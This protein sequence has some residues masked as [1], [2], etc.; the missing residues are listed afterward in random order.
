[1]GIDWDDL[2]LAF[3]HDPPDKALRIKG[4][5][6][7]GARYASAALGEEITKTKLHDYSRT[8]DQLASMIERLPTPAPGL[9]PSLMVS[10]EDGGKLFIRHPISGDEI[11][12]TGCEINEQTVL[13]VISELVSGHEEPENRFLAVWRMLP[14]KLTLENDWY[15][16]LP[17]DTRV[18]DHTIWNH[19]DIT[20]ALHAA[21]SEKHGPAFLSFFLGPVQSFIASARSV[22]DLW[23][24]SAI[25]SWLTFQ[26][27]LPIIKTFGP[28]AVVFPSLRGLPWLDLWLRVERNLVDQ[29]PKPSAQDLKSPC[30]PNRFLAVVPWGDNGS[31]AKVLAG[32]CEKAV[33]ENWRK[34]SS[35]VRNELDHI[36]SKN[37]SDWSKRWEDQVESLFEIRS[38]VL[39]WRSS[40]NKTMSSL[41]SQNRE[42]DY[43]WIEAGKIQRLAKAIPDKDQPGYDQDHVGQWQARFELS[44]RLMDARRSIRHIP[45][46]KATRPTPPK[47]TLMGTYEQM[48]PDDLKES[49]KFWENVS[50]FVSI[51]GVRLQ[52]SE[53]FCAISLVKR[54]AFPAFLADKIGLDWAEVGFPDTAT[55]A[56][57]SWLPKAHLDPDNLRMICRRENTHWN[58][59]WLH[60]PK[61][62][63]DPDEKVPLVVWNLIRNAKAYMESS[64]VKAGPPPTYYA[65]LMMDGDEMGKWLRGDKGSLVGQVYQQKIVKYYE[66]LTQ[67][68]PEVKEALQARRPL[69]P[70]LH[71]AISQALANFAIHIAPHIVARH[72][73]TL[74]YAGGDDVLALLPTSTA[75]TC[76]LELRQAFSGCKE[77]NGSA[78]EGYYRHNGHD[79]LVMGPTASLS[80]GLAIVHYKD[81][82]RQV[83]QAA[84][85]AEKAAKN[86]GRDA[87][88]ITVC[89]RSGGETTALC[90]WDMVKTLE[91]WLEAFSQDASDRWTYHLRSE[92]ETIS[93]LPQA[94]IKAEISRVINRAE[95]ETRKLLGETESR[96]AG[97]IL[98]EEY[99]NYRNKM[100]DRK[101][102]CSISTGSSEKELGNFITLCQAASF[103][104]R[105]RDR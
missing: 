48:G 100:E 10:P 2:M 103:L 73:G 56:A 81:D 29:I 82:L 37:H 63:F 92:Q 84:R 53:R 57:A 46:Y 31:T 91:K 44:S 51:G 19:M 64:V 40:D 94:A 69:G 71:A 22:R 16:N 41:F 34:I 28:A 95:K 90:P 27:M 58:G 75:L 14:D 59:Q 89:R 42:F 18:P 72:C 104:A 101:K 20:A 70:A 26:A 17:A 78:P 88:Q 24:G 9:D 23:S 96:S 38:V 45:P 13:Q 15:A 67:D 76:A 97:E 60:W 1:M 77:T 87:L 12:L 55:V 11:Q 3:L 6:F 85:S 43:V 49:P 79:L 32:E 39:P 21:L 99:I 74:I 25:L 54:F 47:C 30:I 83:L 7:R 80:A 33:R 52:K 105:G 50:E 61:P 65:V 98:A 8:E 102:I 62:D 4:H 35:A 66:R 93:F 86:Q 68:K 36:F 5:E